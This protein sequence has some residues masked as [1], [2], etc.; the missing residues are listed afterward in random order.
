MI[1]HVNKKLCGHSGQGQNLSEN[2][3]VTKTT[4]K[5]YTELIKGTDER[6]IQKR[7]DP[8]SFKQLFCHDKYEMARK[9]K[10]ENHHQSKP[11]GPSVLEF[12]NVPIFCSFYSLKV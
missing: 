5:K 4:Y 3:K 2:G 8:K 11:L 9:T 10:P 1:I 6:K 7:E 12:K